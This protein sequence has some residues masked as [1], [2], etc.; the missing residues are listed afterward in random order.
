MA[1]AT[2]ADWSVRFGALDESIDPVIV[3]DGLEQASRRVDEVIGRRPLEP[4]VVTNV[5]WTHETNVSGD[6]HVHLPD[7]PPLYPERWTTTLTALKLYDKWGELQQTVTVGDCVVWPERQGLVILP[8]SNYV[9]D[10][11]TIEASYTCGYGTVATPD[12]P[13]TLVDATLRI[14]EANVGSV[15]TVGRRVDRPVWFVN[16][17]VVDL[18][19]PWMRVPAA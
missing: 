1:Y 19:R 3:T 4:R 18:L 6:R 10:G 14:V 15:L 16:Q 11:W 13:E 17:D 8:D 9:E 12:I 2:T 7:Y 5:R